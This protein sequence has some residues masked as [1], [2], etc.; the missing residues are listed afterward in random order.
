MKA[1]IA[2]VC[3][4]LLGIGT[5]VVA[6]WSSKQPF[7]V[8]CEWLDIQICDS[9]THQYVSAEELQRT[10]QRNGVMPVGKAMLEVSCQAIEECLLQHDMVRTAECYKISTGGI[11][12]KVK[13][14]IPMFYVSTA[15]GS[16][17]VDTDRKIM[18]VRSAIEVDVPILKGAVSRTDATQEYYD[19]VAWLMN[20]HYWEKRITHI[21]VR[22]SKHI[23][24]SQREV[25]GNIILGALDDY[26]KKLLRLR[27]LYVKGL[28]KIGYKSYREYDLRYDGQVIGRY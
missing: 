20:D 14:R 19:F 2:I 7:D 5:L 10:L 12:V 17:F 3:A 21:H 9:A 6:V 4:I 8:T 11:C 27:K 15:E 25:E 18:P 28:D 13:Q 16:F 23:V 26:E 22:N 24:L 1:K